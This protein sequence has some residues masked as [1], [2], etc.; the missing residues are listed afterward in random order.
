MNDIKKY[1]INKSQLMYF[2]WRKR[3]KK[4]LWHQSGK[5]KKKKMFQDIVAEQVMLWHDVQWMQP[6]RFDVRILRYYS[7][8]HLIPAAVP[9]ARKGHIRH[10]P[11]LRITYGG[12]LLISWHGS[13]SLV[14][15]D[16]EAYVAWTRLATRLSR[17]PRCGCGPVSLGGLV[18]RCRW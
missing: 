11:H 5:R 1:R 3:K 2:W 9:E 14:S 4:E 12:A 15:L 7:F 16:F 17:E 10:L 18:R 8:K 13:L 6:H